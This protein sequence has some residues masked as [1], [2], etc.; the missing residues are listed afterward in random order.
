M[1]MHSRFSLLIIGALAIVGGDSAFGTLADYQAAVTN[2]TGLVSY[3]RFDATN[4]NDSLGQH[5]GTTQ[6]GA[7]FGPGIGNSGRSLLLNG[8]GR[9]NL[10]QVSDFDF[11]DG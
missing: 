11:A 10:G 7:S 1:T 8:A 6:G 3:Y 5:N 2:E 4:A 9:V